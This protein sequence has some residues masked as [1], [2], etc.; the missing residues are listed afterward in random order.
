[1]FTSF[2]VRPQC[3]FCDNICDMIHPLAL[4]CSR[5]NRTFDVCNDCAASRVNNPCPNC[6]SKALSII[7]TYLGSCFV[8][9]QEEKDILEQDALECNLNQNK[10]IDNTSYNY[11]DA[12]VYWLNMLFATGWGIQKIGHFLAEIDTHHIR[13]VIRQ[14]FDADSALFLSVEQWKEL[15]HYYRHIVNIT[16]C[17]NPKNRQRTILRNI[18]NAIDI[19]CGSLV[20][21]MNPKISINAKVTIL[22]YAN[23]LALNG[24]RVQSIG[25]EIQQLMVKAICEICHNNFNAENIFEIDDIYCIS[26]I[27]QQVNIVLPTNANNVKRYLAFQS[28]S[29]IPC[30]RYKNV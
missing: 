23:A 29:E 8:S 22:A 26:G 24:F 2:L 16:S 6:G 21:E 27:L 18:E 4:K 19:L 7:R 12:I 10:H 9:Q 11:Q 14:M 3:H 25:D 15:Y 28:G 13:T 20:N 30:V 17:K 1:M 5:C